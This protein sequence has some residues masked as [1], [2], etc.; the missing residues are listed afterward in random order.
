MTIYGDMKHILRRFGEHRAVS[1]EWKH[2]E[3]IATTEKPRYRARYSYSTSSF[4]SRSSSIRAKVRRINRE[5]NTRRKKARCVISLP[6]RP[7]AKIIV[8][9]F[10][11]NFPLISTQYARHGIKVGKRPNRYNQAVEKHFGQLP[12]I[13]RRALR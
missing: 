9:L 10:P 5:R 1:R 13:F 6:A 8:T 11:H 12:M 2:F 7:D 3:K 4:R